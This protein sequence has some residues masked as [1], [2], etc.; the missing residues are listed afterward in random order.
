MNETPPIE[1]LDVDGVAGEPIEL[2][3][4]TGPA[5]GHEWLLELP[6]GL[7]QIDEAPGRPIDPEHRLGG[8]E[9]GRLR[10]TAPSGDH[11]IVARLARPWEPDQPV[12]VA[13]IRLHVR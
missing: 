3:L 6:P 9:G 1:E 7:L 8:A 5:T 11:E 4:A 2:P 10:V 12:R 13:H